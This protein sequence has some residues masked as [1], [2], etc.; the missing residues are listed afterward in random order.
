MSQAHSRPGEAGESPIPR[1]NVVVAVLALGG[2]VVSLMQTLVIP[3]G[4]LPAHRHAS[5]LLRNRRR[6]GVHGR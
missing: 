3:I 5:V 4:R 6:R 1:T 2:I